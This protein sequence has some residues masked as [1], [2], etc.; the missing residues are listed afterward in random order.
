MATNNTSERIV[1]VELGTGSV[2]HVLA[3]IHIA[4]EDADKGMDD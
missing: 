2:R 3:G 1:D 4:S